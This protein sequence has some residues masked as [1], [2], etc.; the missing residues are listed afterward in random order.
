MPIKPSEKEEEYFLKLETAKLK[1]LAE[2][3]DKEMKKKERDE[4]KKLHWMHCPKCGQKLET[5][6]ITNVEVDRCFHCNGVWLDEG[7]LEKISSA[8][9]NRKNI[10][11]SMVKIFK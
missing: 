5:I 9:K 11:S 2:E 6:N 7:E 4:L 10:I 3:R 8:E 1:K